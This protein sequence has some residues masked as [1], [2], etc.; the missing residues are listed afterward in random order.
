[1]PV[2]VENTENSIMQ[3]DLKEIHELIANTG[4]FIVGL[5]AAAAIFHHY[6]MRDNTL[7]RMLPGKH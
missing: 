7:L 4:Y 2:A 3:H 1:M 6:I 5:H